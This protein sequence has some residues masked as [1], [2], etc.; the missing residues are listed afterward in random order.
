MQVGLSYP[1]GNNVIQC[2]KLLNL[3]SDLY[4]ESISDKELIIS[5]GILELGKPGG[6]IMTDGIA[7]IVKNI[8]F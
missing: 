1:P 2:H 3:Y 6:V 8:H 4:G 5:I 7:D